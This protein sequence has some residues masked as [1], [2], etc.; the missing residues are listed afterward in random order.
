MED[1]LS[2][3]EEQVARVSQEVVRLTR[4]TMIAGFV[5]LGI[6]LVGG[7]IVPSYAL[8]VLLT[9]GCVVYIAAIFIDVLARRAQRRRQRHID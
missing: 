1:R 9:V 8:V 6:L 7:L 5:A 4:L 3:L 2:K